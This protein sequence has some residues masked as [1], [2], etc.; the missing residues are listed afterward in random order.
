M[1]PWLGKEVE[2]GLPPGV[3][4]I[5]CRCWIGGSWKNPI[6]RVPVTEKH[7]QGPLAFVGVPA[8]LFSAD[9]TVGMVNPIAE[10][11]LICGADSDVVLL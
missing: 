10:H 8:A 1:D 11:D 7:D 3:F 6:L 5:G 2:T 9:L 4:W